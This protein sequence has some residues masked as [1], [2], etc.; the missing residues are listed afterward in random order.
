VKGAYFEIVASPTPPAP[1]TP[2]PEVMCWNGGYQYLYRNN[3]QAGKFCKCAQG[4]YGYKSYV[5]KIARATVYQY[6]DTGNNENWS[7]T[8]RSSN[9]PVYQVTCTDGVAYLTNN[10]YYWPK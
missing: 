5:S 9:L 10:N 4:T 6:V 2:T 3:G 8:S 1:P 7:V